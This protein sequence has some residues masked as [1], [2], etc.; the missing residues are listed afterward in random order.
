[1]S[2]SSSQTL[3]LRRTE[4]KV[5]LADSKSDPSSPLDSQDFRPA[6]WVPGPHLQ[7]IW[8]SL[9]RSRRLVRFRRELLEAPDGDELVL[10]HVEGSEGRGA[11]RSGAPRLILL[12][13]LEG[14]SYS[15]YVQGLAREAHRRGWSVTAFNFR[16]ALATPP[17]P[18]M[19]P[20]RARASPTP[21]DRGSRLRI[22]TAFR[23]RAQG[24]A[25]RGRYSSRNARSSGS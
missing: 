19:L 20:N 11:P 10:D 25:S 14:S 5:S 16:P 13:G 12:H 3:K 24:G 18:A 8:G 17:T 9:T 6:W 22:R 4:G 7:T 15:V 23:A 21:R 2:S 1:M